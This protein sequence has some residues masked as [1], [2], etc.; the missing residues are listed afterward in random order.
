M[1]PTRRDNGLDQQQW[2]IGMQTW[3]V[4]APPW[5]PDPD[6]FASPLVS[7][8]VAM[9]GGFI[10]IA[11]GMMALVVGPPACG[12]S[13]MVLGV[14]VTAFVVGVLPRHAR[15]QGPQLV[16]SLGPSHLEI[17]TDWPGAPADRLAATLAGLSWSDAGGRRIPWSDLRDA[18]LS[19][20]RN[21]LELRLRSSKPLRL[22]VAGSRHYNHTLE[23]IAKQLEA[24]ARRVGGGHVPRELQQLRDV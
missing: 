3:E 9:G 23:D 5:L 20:D 24:H 6:V 2:R 19:K 4:R 1:K 15:F 14:A 18:R 13:A 12:A 16:L 17:S 8:G 11:L 10:G 21:V 22:P 7:L